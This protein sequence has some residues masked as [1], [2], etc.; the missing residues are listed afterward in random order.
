M[1]YKT[2]SIYEYNNN[3]YLI[4]NHRLKSRI[5]IVC[6]LNKKIDKKETVTRIKIYVKRINKSL[7]FK[8][9]NVRIITTEHLK[10]YIEEIDLNTIFKDKKNLMEEVLWKI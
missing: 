8:S 7:Y 6:L 10:N 9:E 5:A 4:I 2:G 3:Y 1:K